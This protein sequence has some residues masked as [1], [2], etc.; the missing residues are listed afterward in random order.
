MRPD[1][2]AHLR[3]DPAAHLPYRQD[4]R[5][6]R[7]PR[8]VWAAARALRGVALIKTSTIVLAVALI[9]TLAVALIGTLVDEMVGTAT[10][11]AET[12]IGRFPAR[13]IGRATGTTRGTA[14][15]TAAR[16]PAGEFADDS[17]SADQ[18]AMPTPQSLSQ[19]DA[20]AAKKPIEPSG[21]GPYKVQLGA[22]GNQKR[23][24]LGWD[25]L[26]AAAKDL[27]G[28]LPHSILRADLGTEKGVVYR[29]RT[30]NMATRAE[31]KSLC[32]ELKKRE[33][34]CFV[35]GLVDPGTAG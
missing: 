1:P 22:Y 31:A 27:L 12:D 4:G 2:A 15:Q 13:V 16:M 7:P 32:G 34:A 28:R 21:A 8:E 3:P 9:G 20:D 24:R 26:S 25:N 10:K 23:A 17:M 11:S 30:G 14:E 5:Q 29:L 19:S 33:I 6:G 35:V 18:S